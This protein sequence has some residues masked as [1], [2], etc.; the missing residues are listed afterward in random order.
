MFFPY[1]DDNPRRH[2]PPAATLAIIG[3]CT[4]VYLLVQFPLGPHEGQAYALSFGLAFLRFALRRVA[5]R[6]LPSH[7]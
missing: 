2:G 6:S 7:R 1:R 5:Q 3:V 4:V